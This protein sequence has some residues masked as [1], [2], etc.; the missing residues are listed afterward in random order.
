MPLFI[1]LFA[2]AFSRDAHAS[3]FRHFKI[4]DQDKW[5][6]FGDLAPV[7]KS[8]SFD[9]DPLIDGPIYRRMMEYF[10]QHYQSITERQLRLVEGD[11]AFFKGGYNHLA[12]DYFKP[13]SYFSVEFQRQMAPY[14]S[15]D[16]YVINDTINIYIDATQLLGELK[17][18]GII[19]IGQKQLLGFAGVMF[20]R[21]YQYSS[22]AKNKT[23]AMTLYLRR[24]FFS[25]LKFRSQKFLEM[26]P[27]EVM[28]RTDRF[29]FQAGGIGNFP[30]YEYLPTH[31]SEGA[32]S[33]GAELEGEEDSPV[34]YFPVG[35]FIAVNLHGHLAHHLLTRTEIMAVDS[36]E[37][38]F[39]NMREARARALRETIPFKD[40]YRSGDEEIIAEES[41]K[42]AKDDAPTETPPR[43]LSFQITLEKA[44]LSQTGFQASILADFFKLLRTKIFNFNLTSSF[45]NS[46]VMTFGFGPRDAAKIK[47][48]GPLG[49]EVR[50][51][52]KGKEPNLGILKPHLLGKTFRESKA[53]RRTCTLFTRGRSKLQKT[54]R[55]EIIGDTKYKNFFRHEFS[56]R[57]T[58]DSSLGWLISLGLQS[59][60]R[61]S[62]KFGGQSYRDVHKLA[63]EYES[64]KNLLKDKAS[65]DLREER[66]RFAFHFKRE[67]YYQKKG[68][69][70]SKGKLLD[71][72]ENYS[73][74]KSSIVEKVKRGQLVAPFDLKINFTF[75]QSAI[76]HFH[77]LSPEDISQKIESICRPDGPRSGNKKC[78]KKL[79]QSYQRY[80]KE[81]DQRYYSAREKYQKCRRASLPRKRS[82]SCPK[83]IVVRAGGEQFLKR[84]PLW[85]L[86]PF[87]QELQKWG[88]NT[89]AIYSLFGQDNVSMNGIFQA[90]YDS[91][92]R[93]FTSF[94][95]RSSPRPKGLIEQNLPGIRGR[96]LP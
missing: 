93:R 6:N 59:F 58:Q 34:N 56:Q 30:V 90:S 9:A 88:Q 21:S 44:K 41:T 22:F 8:F 17:Q 83:K 37:E 27:E 86:A 25:F 51:M 75:K 39:S 55:V 4:A 54:E 2:L 82:R 52:L 72:I 65:L 13:F 36:E 45:E 49:S 33:P 18:R 68:K 78:R 10:S 29:T 67:F 74:L 85:R 14:I 76:E 94:F 1:L 50:R 66:P 24:L 91:E 5:D 57:H 79:R 64:Q 12:F 84:I 48:P 20:K 77:N 19:D 40:R 71:L 35:N 28:V 43:P 60:L 23:E 47:G 87:L 53:H 32:G 89:S 16:S 38:D 70:K 92:D 11:S 63:I 96:P 46:S 31:D 62:W 69:E 26:R 95:N 15:G 73:T 81:R 3:E 80:I 61:M 7:N 42:E